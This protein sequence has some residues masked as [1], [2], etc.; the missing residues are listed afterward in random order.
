MR[1]ARGGSGELGGMGF[2]EREYGRGRGGLEGARFC[3]GRASLEKVIGEVE[4]IKAAKSGR[5]RR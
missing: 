1:R 5:R 2:S 3:E 4:M